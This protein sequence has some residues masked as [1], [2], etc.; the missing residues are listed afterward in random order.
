MLLLPLFTRIS[1]FISIVANNLSRASMLLDC[2]VSGTAL[3][4]NII[5]IKK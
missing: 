5:E 4:N 1:S 3:I 2:R